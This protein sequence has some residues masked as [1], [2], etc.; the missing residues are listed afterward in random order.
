MRIVPFSE[1]PGHGDRVVNLD[2]LIH[3]RFLNG[4]LNMHFATSPDP[5]TV[6]GEAAKQLWSEITGI[7]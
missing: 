4:M 5:L 2:L 7:Q 6:S 3:A 1:G